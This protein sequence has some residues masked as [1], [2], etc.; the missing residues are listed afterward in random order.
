MRNVAFLYDFHALVG[1][2]NV[3][4]LGAVN[5]LLFEFFC[6]KF[7]EFFVVDFASG[8]DI[9]RDFV[10]DLTPVF[11][12]LLARERLDL[13]DVSGDG[14]R[15]A[16]TFKMDGVEDVA[17][18]LFGNVVVAV[19]FLDDDV[20]FLFHLFLVETRV[21]EHVGDDVDGEF[22]VAAFDLRV[23][24]GLL[25]GRVGFEVSAA[26]F[27]GVCYFECGA[28]FGSLENEVLVK[29][30]EPEF[31]LGFVAAPAWNPD[32]DCRGVGVRHVVR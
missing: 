22:H 32:A 24:A 28:V 18:E 13:L 3:L 26:V 6:T 29:V 17:Y 21:H 12:H 16:A 15:D 10:G 23:K 31:I 4:R 8:A 25:A 27:D 9:Q 20:A 2:V 7:Y 30:A 19:D 14:V 1:F 5:F 11:E